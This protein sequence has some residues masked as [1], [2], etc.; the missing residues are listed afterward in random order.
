M[1]ENLDKV[2]WAELGAPQVPDLLREIQADEPG[3]EKDEKRQTAWAEL[4]E[5]I[6]PQEII[7]MW[8]WS[9][10]GRMMQN[11]LPH[12]VVMF[13]LEILEQTTSKSTQSILIGHLREMGMYWNISL[14]VGDPGQR[15]YEAYVEWAN[16]LKEVIRQGVPLYKQLLDDPYPHLDQNVR[17]LLEDLGE[18]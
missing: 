4:I 2:N 13:L 11:D 6:F 3:R 14:W 1:L 5:L 18:A 9:A 12:K 16:R 8:D 15:R 10:P 17:A 7:E